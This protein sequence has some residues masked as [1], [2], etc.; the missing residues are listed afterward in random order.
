MA[1]C[2]FCLREEQTDTVDFTDEHVFPAAIGGNIVVMD[3]SCDGC[4]H[5]KSKFEQ[6]L[7]GELTPIR[8][9]LQI[10]DRYG[11][12]PHAAATIITPAET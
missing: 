1:Q 11:K 7:A 6:A 12:V 8:M 3:G 4:N 10:P 9:L 2:L 5:G